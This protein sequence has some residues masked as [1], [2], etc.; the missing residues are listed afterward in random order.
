MFR[1]VELPKPLFE[2]LEC[3]EFQLAFDLPHQSDRVIFARH[4]RDRCPVLLGDLGEPLQECRFPS[5]VITVEKEGLPT[6]RQYIRS[7]GVDV[8]V[9]VY[10]QVNLASAVRHQCTVFTHLS[11]RAGRD[12]L[13]PSRTAEPDGLAPALSGAALLS[14]LGAPSPMMSRNSASWRFAR[15]PTRVEP[16][17]EG[18]VVVPTM[19]RN[20]APEASS[21][22]SAVRSVR[23]R[24][25]DRK[26]RTARQWHRTATRTHRGGVVHAALAARGRDLVLSCHWSLRGAARWCPGGRVGLPARGHHS[27]CSARSGGGQGTW[28]CRGRRQAGQFAGQNGLGRYSRIPRMTPEL[29]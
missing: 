13:A 17:R 2:I 6:T 5:A 4:L 16:A 24:Q 25:V 8:F 12:G 1:A 26:A 27:G 21:P 18:L 14:A 29:A 28:E 15:L 22:Q 19:S 9:S 10:E 11:E 20:F 23:S 7:E 3:V